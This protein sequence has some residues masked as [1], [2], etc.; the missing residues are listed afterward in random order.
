MEVWRYINKKRGRKI[1]KKNN[2]DEE[3][4]KK[5][6]KELPGGTDGGGGWS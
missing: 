6:F 2:I 5:Y 1:V 3:V 4:W